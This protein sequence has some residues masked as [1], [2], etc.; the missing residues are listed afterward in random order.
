MVNNCKI[1]NYWQLFFA[2]ISP[3][4]GQ[5]FYNAAHSPDLNP[6]VNIW[7]HIKLF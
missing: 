2:S 7:S 1:S 4:T 6:I 5:F 3:F